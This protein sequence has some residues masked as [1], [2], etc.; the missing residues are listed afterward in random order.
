MIVMDASAL[1]EA[2]LG[3]PAAEE[4]EEWLFDTEQ[5]VH[6]PHLLDIEVTQV[7]RKYTAR[8]DIAAATGRA[9]VAD[10]ANLRLYWHSHELLLPRVWELRANLTAYDA[11][12]VALA[13]A[14]D[15]PLVT[16]DRRIAA[17]PGHHAR[18]EVI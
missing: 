13:E 3:M 14:L 9:A 6:V 15:A 17:A 8:G 11:V 12:Y 1:V 18:V 10:L 4:V 7:V 16:R 5:T 2:L